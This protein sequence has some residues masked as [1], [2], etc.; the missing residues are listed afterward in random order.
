M[1]PYRQVRR[2]VGACAVVALAATLAACGGSNPSSAP[3]SHPTTTVAIITTNWETFFDAKT[4]VSQRVALLENGSQFP[5]ALLEATGLA[6]TATA[7]VTSV[8]NV[9]SSQA[10]VKYD[11]LLGNAPALPHQTGTAV[12]EDGTWKV[13]TASFCGLLKMEIKAQDIPAVCKTATS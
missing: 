4:P 11:V 5:K 9:T 13:G 8:I 10:T 1:D 12:Y 3:S 2:L 6:A 7:K